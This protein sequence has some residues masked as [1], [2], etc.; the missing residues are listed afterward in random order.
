MQTS[1]TACRLLS[2]IEGLRSS[3]QLQTLTARD[4]VV[5]TD[6]H[7]ITSAGRTGPRFDGQRSLRSGPAPLATGAAVHLGAAAPGVDGG[8]KRCPQR[9]AWALPEPGTSSTC[10]TS[11]RAAPPPAAAAGLAPVSMNEARL[12]DGRPTL[13]VRSF[14]ATRKS[15]RMS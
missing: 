3:G 12:S 9:W 14:H 11:T 2:T 6:G 4:V 13:G 15:A 8:A 5:Q 7:W 10:A 1:E